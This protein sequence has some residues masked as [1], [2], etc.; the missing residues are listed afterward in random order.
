[1]SVF[2]PHFSCCC[3]LTPVLFI[4]GLIPAVDIGGPT[5]RCV[6]IRIHVALFV[7]LSASPHLHRAVWL[8]TL[9]N[10]FLSEAA[11]GP[12][13]SWLATWK[14]LS[15]AWCPVRALSLP[16]GA[17]SLP[18]GALSLPPG[19]LGHESWPGFCGDTTS[20]W[21]LAGWFLRPSLGRRV[22]GLSAG[23]GLTGDISAVCR[24]QH[25]LFPLPQI[26]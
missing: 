25:P 1:M 9:H 11:G 4:L 8:S 26:N 3:N 15:R 18:L 13:C 21:S 2:P 7:V 10:A 14:M 19:A 12:L 5:R 20:G 22:E 23:R 16:S 24:D 6:L 17:L